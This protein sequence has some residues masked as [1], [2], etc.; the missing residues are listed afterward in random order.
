M[1]R[2]EI[3]KEGEGSLNSAHTHTPEEKERKTHTKERCKCNRDK[4]T[5]DRGLQGV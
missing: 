2:I 5:S 1:V 3:L 4:T